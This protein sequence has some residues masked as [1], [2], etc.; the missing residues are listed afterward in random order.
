MNMGL[1]KYSID[2][3]SRRIFFLAVVPWCIGLE[4]K[5]PA[6]KNSF[7]YGAWD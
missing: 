6:E 5:N 3:D 7:G 4:K 2:L 1:G